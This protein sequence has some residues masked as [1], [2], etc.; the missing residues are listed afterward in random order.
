LTLTHSLVPPHPDLAE[1]QEADARSLGMQLVSK[2]EEIATLM[3]QTGGEAH[4]A[5]LAAQRCARSNKLQSVGDVAQAQ[6]TIA[7][8]LETAAKV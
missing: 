4:E 6:A 5:L 1:L 7:A 2:R 8:A 3:Q